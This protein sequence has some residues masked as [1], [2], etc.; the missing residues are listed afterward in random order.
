MEDVTVD[1]LIERFADSS[2]LYVINFVTIERL[3][4]WRRERLPLVFAVVVVVWGGS[5]TN[6]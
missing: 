1:T 3:Y 6:T 5:Y 4:I 2:W